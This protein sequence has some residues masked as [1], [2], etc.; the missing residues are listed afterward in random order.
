MM[1]VRLL[2]LLLTIKKSSLKLK[3]TSEKVN[4]NEADSVTLDSSNDATK[5]FTTTADDKKVK[6]K[7]K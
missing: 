2:L 4:S 6:V 3:G 5:N 1:L 7:S